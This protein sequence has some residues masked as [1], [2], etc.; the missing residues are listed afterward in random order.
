MNTLSAEDLPAYVAGARLLVSSASDTG[1]DALVDWVDELLRRNGP[2]PL[3]GLDEVDGETLTAAIGILG[4]PA[5][6]AELPPVGDEPEAIVRALEDRLGEKLGAVMPLNAALVNALFP[7]AAAASLGLPLLDCDGMGRIFPLIHQTSYALAGIPLTPLTAAS[8]IGDRITMDAAPV[9]AERLMRAAMNSAGGW[10]LCAMHSCRVAELRAGAIRGS[11][12]RLVRV[13]ELLRTAADHGAVLAGLKRTLRARR[14]GSGRVVELGHGT[15]PA[16]AGYPATPTSVVVHE[17]HSSGRLIRL[18]A[19][20]ELLLA[21]I[22]G[23]VAAAVPDVLCLLDR[24]EV[25]IIGLERVAIGD[26]VDVLVVP[27]AP[28]WHSAEGL[29]L[30]GPRAF[31]FPVQHPGRKPTS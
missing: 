11:V 24:Q 28:V 18:E 10:M 29:A 15:R 9:R 3:L 14:L 27:A 23:A 25:R 12:S 2:V 16:E 1:M 5:A 30:A 8:A 17:T 31:G 19:Q 21:V 7:V 6:T 26:H 13:G 22:D 20:N 4:S